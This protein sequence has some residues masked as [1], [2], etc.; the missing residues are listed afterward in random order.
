MFRRLLLLASLSLFGCETDA[1]FD[2]NP[3]ELRLDVPATLSFV[4]GEAS[5]ITIT[6]TAAD[7][8]GDAVTI[9]M[10]QPPPTANFDER[11]GWAVMSWAP[12]ASDVTPAG[13]PRNLI[14]FADDGRG[15]RTERVV[16]VTILA[17]NGLPRFLNSPSV[18]H[19][20]DANKPLIFDVTVRDDDSS[21]VAIAMPTAT[22]PV[23]ASYIATGDKSGR[24]EWLPTEAQI[25]TRVHTVTF[26]ANDG[27]NPEVSQKVTI[28]LSKTSTTNDR[29]DDEDPQNPN[30]CTSDDVVRHTV[31][32]AQRGTNDYRIEATLAPQ[33]AARYDRMVLNFS[34]GDV[35]NDASVQLQGEE[36]RN[37]AGTFVG[38]IPN[39]LLP[40]GQSRTY[41]YHLCAIDDDSTEDD[42]IVC[43]PP[44]YHSFI[45]YAPN[46]TS[47]L[48]DGGAH[49]SFDSA[50]DLATLG[51]D[52]QAR[53]S[54]AGTDDYY[55]MTIPPG[56]EAD[57]YVVYP[58]GGGT[59][60]TMYDEARAPLPLDVAACS[61]S[62][63]DFFTNETAQPL[64]R[65]IKVSGD[66]TPYQISSYFYE[67]IAACEDN[68]AFTGNDSE[69]S[70]AEV[71]PTLYAGLTLCGGGA[72]WYSFLAF[73]SERI[74]VDIDVT[75]GDPNAASLTVWHGG[76]PLAFGVQG[77]NRHR[78][79]FNAPADG[80]Y[81]FEVT[82][83]EPLTYSLTITFE[84]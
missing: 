53:R 12:I 81:F 11:D 76:S 47:C 62:T 58:A 83:T 40:D 42:A 21:R 46:S 60:V 31:L 48:D 22:A 4:I 14:F 24:F 51:L 72:D 6:A 20:V 66:N 29:P 80:D 49:G 19:S 57:I 32:N 2:N 61:S 30:A 45:A 70:A 74:T 64:T 28:M 65:Y 55:R 69:A 17:G 25:E 41:Y 5:R 82:A 10:V 16:S 8:D 15:G 54:C 78:A 84:I 44:L 79:V 75:T 56:S 9:G 77:G 23:G 36:M 33:A 38:T 63:Y 71:D 7:P 26:V 13:T 35:Y 68:D 18:S 73:A 59:T 39:P 27:Q 37:E 52:W 34:D 43:D 3:P 67:P 1:P 50:V